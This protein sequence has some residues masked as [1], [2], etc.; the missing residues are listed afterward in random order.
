VRIARLTIY[1]CLTVGVCVAAADQQQTDKPRSKQQATTSPDTPEGLL[2]R[3]YVNGHGLSTEE[4]CFQLVSLSYAAGHLH[5]VHARELTTLWSKELFKEASALPPSGNRPAFKKN[6]VEA[7]SAV[8]PVGAFKLLTRIDAPEN[9]ASEDLRASAAEEIFE[10]LW[11][12][13]GQPALHA[14]K[15]KA[16]EIGT[17]GEYPYLA[18]GLISTKLIGKAQADTAQTIFRE[19]LGFYD[20]GP[21]VRSADTQFVTYLKGSWTSLPAAL[22]EE[23]LRIVVAHLTR[24]RNPDAN[25]TEMGRI[26]TSKGIAFFHSAQMTLLYS[27]LPKIRELDP[28]W[29]SHLEDEHSDLKQAASN[30]TFQYESN[31]KVVNEAGA[32]SDQVAA[33]GDHMLQ[34]GA[35]SRIK[36]Q[37]MTNPEEAS[38]L[39]ASVNDPELQAEALA[40]LALGY[41]TRDPRR[42]SDLLVTAQKGA[43]KLP[44]G[45]PKLRALTSLAE[46]SAGLGDLQHAEDAMQK[47]FDLGEE[48]VN[49]D[50]DMHP[51][52]SVDQTEA[53]EE[54][55]SVTRL[56][57][58]VE[59]GA[60]M[61][62]LDHLRDDALRTF[63]LIAAAEGLQ[64]MSVADKS[65]SP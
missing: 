20:D 65:A 51:G 54:L 40:N 7:L 2:W 57:A 13:K 52:E 62:R 53:F 59:F 34:L 24:E 11:E 35:L 9:N 39:L 42:A 6:S 21:R 45:L 61:R 32:A 15:S 25:V 44:S 43:D 23:S 10:R 48:L 29:A 27:L 12:V 37:A 58:R 41:A 18:M 33:V 63:L 47:A 16:R 56:G 22:R 46:S 14:I 60:T 50:R 5:S 30:G 3:S 38:Q 1:I 26:S 17:T 36:A 31:V 49:E 4:R 55:A 64:H 19:A 28:E 8:D